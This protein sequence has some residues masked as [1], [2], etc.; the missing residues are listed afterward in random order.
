MNWYVMEIEYALNPQGSF[1]RCIGVL[2]AY[3]K[4]TMVGFALP[5]IYC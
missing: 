1:N 2:K 5:C 4:L 3:T